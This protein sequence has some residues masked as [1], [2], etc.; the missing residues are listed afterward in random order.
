[1]NDDELL[2]YSRHILLPQVDIAGQETICNSKVLI[3]GAG[4]LGSPV[5]MYL[6]A[7]GVGELIISDDDEVDTSNLQR[8]ILHSEASVGTNKSTSARASIQEI[9]S[10]THVTSIEYR[11]DEDALTS[12]LPN[13]DVVVDCSDN[14]ATRILLNRMCFMTKRPLV[15]GAA[16]R[17]EG[18]LSVF[19][20]RDV[21]SP[22]Y[23]CIFESIDDSQL[24]C[25]ESGVFSPIVGIVG[26]MQALE[27]LKLIVGLKV[28]SVGRLGLFDGLKNQWR[29]MNVSKNTAC[30]TCGGSHQ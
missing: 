13:I 27:A 25:S 1:M 24:S 4:G 19:D 26:C 11:L 14:F 28:S 7:A 22:C 12:L 30:K 2:R 23:E 29:Y 8:Q 6:A 9:N 5:A 20:F 15:F 17:F 21:D 16:I 10:H 18:Q 3:I